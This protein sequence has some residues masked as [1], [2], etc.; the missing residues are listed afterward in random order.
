MW[1]YWGN[2]QPLVS[3][4]SVAQQ[5][6]AFWD[7]LLVSYGYWAGRKRWFI[8]IVIIDWCYKARMNHTKFNLHRLD[9]NS[10]MLLL[11][12]SC[13]SFYKSIMQ[14]SCVMT[15]LVSDLQLISIRWIYP[16]LLF[17]RSHKFKNDWDFDLTLFWCFHNH[18]SLKMTEILI[19]PVLSH[20]TIN[21]KRTNA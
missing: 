7:L 1:Q 16:I 6:E 19:S 11:F 3:C 10:N 12:W 8:I 17:P 21:Q 13:S 4:G 2:Q 15:V 5:K 9:Q 14:F 18:T 20:G